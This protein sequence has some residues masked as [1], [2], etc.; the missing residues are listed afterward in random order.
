MNA[1]ASGDVSQGEESQGDE[2]QTVGAAL[3]AL[4]GDAIP[5]ERAKKNSL[6]SRALAVITSSGTLVTLLLA[7]AALVT[8]TTKFVPTPVTLALLG[9]AAILFTAASCLA[10]Y[11]NAP[12]G[13]YEI[14]PAS[15]KALAAPHAWTADGSEA[16]REL[17][18]AQLDILQDWRGM[19]EAKA[20][21]LGFAT[22]TEVTGL[23]VTAAAVI[24]ILAEA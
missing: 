9:L 10:V 22:L 8:K 17:A 12:G 14:V 21:I 23:L 13:Y 5:A 11:C 2:S 6:E 7:L 24:V 19:N 1:D 15:L 3:A 4:L 20:R 18:L 16:R